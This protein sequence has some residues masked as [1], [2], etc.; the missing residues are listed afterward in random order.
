MQE[1]EVHPLLIYFAIYILMGNV[2]AVDNVMLYWPHFFECT[3]LYFFALISV[4][5]FPASSHSRRP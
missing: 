1:N 5:A 3:A 2:I 4:A